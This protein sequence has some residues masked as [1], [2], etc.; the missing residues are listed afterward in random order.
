MKPERMKET[1][2]WPGWNRNHR[3]THQDLNDLLRV[4]AIILERR[5]QCGGRS[6]VARLQKAREPTVRHAKTYLALA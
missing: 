6:S 2:A 4:H 3:K 5:L 1:V